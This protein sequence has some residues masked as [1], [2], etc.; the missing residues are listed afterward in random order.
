MKTRGFKINLEDDSLEIKGRRID[1]DTT[2]KGHYKIP[3]RSIEDVNIANIEKKSVEDKQ[4]ILEKLHRQFYNPSEKSIK[5]L[6]MNAGEYVMEVKSIIENISNNC[7]FCKR[8][9]KTKARPVV[10]LPMA[11]KFS[12]VVAMDLKQFHNVYFTHFTDLF[13]RYSKAQVIPRKT[14]QA[15]VKAFITEWIAMGPGCPSS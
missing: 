4:R 15:V 11:K 10:C 13:T 3:L 12:D 9:K 5:N 1:L 8:Y 2:E 6:M 7:E 14:P